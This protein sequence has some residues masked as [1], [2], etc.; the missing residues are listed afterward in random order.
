MRDE[1]APDKNEAIVRTIVALARNLDIAVVAEGIENADQLG[2]LRE[3]NC[4][5]GQGFHLQRPLDADQAG[6]LLCAATTTR[7]GAHAG[8]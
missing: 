4:D 1:S 6:A 8:D 7:A 2:R 5:Y 3:M